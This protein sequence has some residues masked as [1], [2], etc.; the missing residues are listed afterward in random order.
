MKKQIVHHPDDFEAVPSR[1]APRGQVIVIDPSKFYFDGPPF[2]ATPYQ[3]R[4]F[5][6]LS[7]SDRPQS[8]RITGTD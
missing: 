1:H 5:G 6:D 8:G 7:V 2:V 3:W 4:L